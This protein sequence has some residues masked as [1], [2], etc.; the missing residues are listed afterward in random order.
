MLYSGVADVCEWYDDSD[1]RFHIEVTVRNRAWGPLFGYRGSF[2]V[3]WFPVKS[4]E[5]PADILPA[6]CERRE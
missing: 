5:I 1:G 3:E 4:G 2:D 6:R